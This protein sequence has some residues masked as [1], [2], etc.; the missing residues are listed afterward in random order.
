MSAVSHP[1]LVDPAARALAGAQLE[2]SYAPELFPRLQ[3]LAVTPVGEVVVCAAFA[4]DPHGQVVVE[5]RLQAQL[6]M[7][8]QTCLQTLTQN[9][10]QQT[11]VA[12]VFNDAA[13]EKVNRD[14][15]AVLLDENG[16]LNLDTVIEDELILALP[17]VPKH[18]DGPCAER[19]NQ[20]LQTDADLVADDK[21]NP[22]AV[23]EKLQ[24]EQTKTGK[25]K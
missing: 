21:P 14:Y 15:D 2:L 13:A 10:Q 4:K 3:D 24:A 20:A 9:L 12:P 18:V 25:S 6:N 11:V 23:L 22:F 16:E 1:I 5:L 8:C 19:L 7:M 17:Q